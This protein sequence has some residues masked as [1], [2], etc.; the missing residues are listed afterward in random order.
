[1]PLLN[2][3]FVLLLSIPGTKVFPWFQPPSR[4]C[5]SPDPRAEQKKDGCTWWFKP[6]AL[7]IPCALHFRFSA[8]SSAS[9]TGSHTLPAHTICAFPSS[10]SLSF[11]P[12][13]SS[14]ST[15][16][17]PL[18][19][20]FMTLISCLLNSSSC[21]YLLHLPLPMMEQSQNKH[22]GFRE[23]RCNGVNHQ[24]HPRIWCFAKGKEHS[25]LSCSVEWV[26][27]IRIWR[28]SLPITNF[29]KV[30]GKALCISEM[31]I[32]SGDLWA[33]ISRQRSKELHQ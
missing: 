5:P 30:L 28:W 24:T 18:S 8:G 20:F 2:R 32:C 10:C 22:S 26:I 33:G 15:H 25:P 11:L 7:Q 4:W 19:S 1:M 27:M 31:W 12:P 13:T 9:S 17:S 29:N 16:H 21:T 6:Q 14:A 3:S 23:Q